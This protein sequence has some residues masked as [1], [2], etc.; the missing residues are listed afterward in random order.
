MTSVILTRRAML[1]GSALVGLGTLLTACGQQAAT[2]AS[3]PASAVNSP[4]ETASAYPGL[5][6]ADPRR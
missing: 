4:S 6:A 2:E 5:A 1:S 3:A